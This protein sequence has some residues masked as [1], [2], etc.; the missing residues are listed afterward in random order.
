M[1]TLSKEAENQLIEAVKRAVDMVDSQGLTPTAA[2]EKVAREERWG[3][4]MIR[5]ASHAYNTGRQTAQ[6]QVGDSVLDKF[7]EFP[8]ADADRVIAAVFPDSVKSAAQIELETSVSA[9]YDLPPQWLDGQRIDKLRKTAST[10][11]VASDAP[12]ESQLDSGERMKHAYSRHLDEK[13]AAEEARYQVSAANDRV[14]AALGQLGDYFKKSAFDRLALADVEHAAVSHYGTTGQRLF[15]YVAQRNRSKEARAAD[16][17]PSLIP[18]NLDA[19]PFT[20]VKACVDAA[21]DLGVKKA[22][23]QTAVGKMKKQ[24]DDLVPFEYASPAPARPFSLIDEPGPQKRA[25]MFGGVLGGTLAD[26]TKGVLDET[27]SDQPAKDEVNSQWMELS[28]PNH[29][30]ELRKIRTQALI[31]ELM[32]DDVIGGYDPQQ[33]VNAYN[34]ISQMAPEASQQPLAVRSLLR[35]HLQGNVEPFEA[36]Q[37]ADIEKAMRPPTANKGLIPDGKLQ[38]QA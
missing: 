7:A 5:F 26:K 10:E 8:L 33:V 18:I 27:L 9:E 30:N 36:Q 31:A 29:E 24:A 19:A 38:L 37:V 23:H 21:K 3:A 4:P 25:S 14:L 17:Q 35:R 16:T 13:R 11:K 15:D 32:N 2:I 28:D 6:R 20:L 22:A 12:T 34:E 1:Q